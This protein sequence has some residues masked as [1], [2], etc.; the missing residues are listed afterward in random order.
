MSP[1]N[2]FRRKKMKAAAIYARVSTTR[3]EEE[4]TIESQIAALE[5]YAADQG[6]QV[7]AAHRFIDQAVSG[8]RL[9]RPALDQLR[10]LASEQAFPVLLCLEPDRLARRYVYQRLILDELS[11]AGVRVIFLSQPAGADSP[12]AELLLGMQGLFAEYERAVIAERMRRG[13]LH[14]L[15]TGQLMPSQAPYGY[16]YVPRDLPGGSQW[17][18]VPEQAA[19]VRDIFSWYQSGL[20]ISALVT[21]L[22][23]APIPGPQGSQWYFSTV[24]RILQEPAYKGCGR[25]NRHQTDQEAIGQLRR[26]GRGRLQTPRYKLRPVEEWITMTVPQIISA[27]VWH[28]VEEQLQMNARFA[29]R[30]NHKHVYLLRGLLTCGICGHTLTGRTTRHKTAYY[31]QYGGVKRAPDVPPH[32]CSIAA[33]EIDPLVWQALTDLLQNPTRLTDAWQA[34]LDPQP[35]QPETLNHLQRR[36]R[37]LQKQWP[38]LLDLYQDELIDKAELRQRKALIEAEQA[39]LSQRLQLAARQQQA[40]HYQAELALTCQAFAQRIEDALASPSF[41]TQQDVIRLLIDHI[42]VTDEAITIKH[43]VPAEDDPRL[44]RLEPTH[45]TA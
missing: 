23:K 19:V 31:C 38:R 4:A 42:V 9:D 15:K 32:R 16:R 28:A 33:A 10:D 26:S 8:Y 5:T 35:P 24:Q 13:K 6:Y 21:R 22:N 20:T 36:Q 43:I 44:C 25:Y 37:D 7:A 3:Q 39:R 45:S 40:Q 11:R 17:L 41:E 14:R 30:N 18:V 2:Q 27:E 1:S 12:Q 29:R 34:L